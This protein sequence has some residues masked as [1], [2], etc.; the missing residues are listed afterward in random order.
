MSEEKKELTLEEKHALTL[1]EKIMHVRISV[2]GVRK[3]GRLNMHGTV[4]EYHT[5]DDINSFNLKMLKEFGVF[6]CSS[7]PEKDGKT[8]GELTISDKNTLKNPILITSIP[9]VLEGKSS[10]DFKY[11][12]NLDSVSKKRIELTEREQIRRTLPISQQDVGASF[13]Y[14]RRYLAY[15]LGFTADRDADTEIFAPAPK[16]APKPKSDHDIAIEALTIM[17]KAERFT[18]LR[19][20]FK[21]VASMKSKEEKLKNEIILEKREK[22]LAIKSLKGIAT[23]E[24]INKLNA[25]INEGEKRRLSGLI[26]ARKNEINSTNTLKTA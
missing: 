5:L 13:T 18:L 26:D 9:F 8:I 11:A 23:I 4:F 7:F 15:A 24:E 2:G 25:N 3:T 22:K 14:H 16:P 12:L 19:P 20:A 1:E 21:L 17:D 6:I 10:L